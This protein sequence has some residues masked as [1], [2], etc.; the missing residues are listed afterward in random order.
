MEYSL[1]EDQQTLRAL[2]RR[3]AEER[4]LPV[5]AELDEK[6]EFP[7]EI[8]KDL[9][10]SDMF[11]VFVPEE[12]DGLGGGCLDLCLVVEEL[13]RVCS[14]VAVSYA[15]SALGASALLRF[16]T[17]QQKQKYLPDIADGK[18]LVAFGLTEPTAGS[19]AGGIRTTAEKT[20]D[21]YVL[22][23]TKQFITNGGDAEIYT[24]IALTD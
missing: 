11:R 24:I 16:G 2:A 3:I 18:R 8:M 21:G 1:T 17:D 10:E 15:A 6:E 20:A 19:D 23:G 4:I 22:N 14:A 9:A 13:S 12:Y 5:R 7:W